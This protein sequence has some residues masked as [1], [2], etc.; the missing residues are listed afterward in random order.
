V[1][2]GA[3]SICANENNEQLLEQFKAAVRNKGELGGWTRGDGA[4]RFPGARCVGTRLSSLSL[5]GVP[6]NV[7]FRVVAGTLL[8]LAIVEA[9]SLRGANISGS[10]ADASGRGWRCGHTL[11]E[12][13]LSGNRGLL[14]G[15]V[16]DAAAP[17]A[18]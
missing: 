4:C 11:A 7:D 10:L 18:G 3:G 6:L 14:R 17:V 12:L 8:R 16:A 13:D 9:I 1:R 15:S 5:A 2:G